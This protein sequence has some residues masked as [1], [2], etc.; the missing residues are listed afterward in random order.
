M[1]KRHGYR[2]DSGRPCWTCG[3]SAKNA[4]GIRVFSYTMI[5]RV[6]GDDGVKRTKN[7][8]TV[9]VCDRC[10][11]EAHRGASGAHPEP[12]TV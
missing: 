9:P 10:I 12:G 11:R 3:I 5:R 4:A 1:V 2:R 6:Q 7:F 8:G